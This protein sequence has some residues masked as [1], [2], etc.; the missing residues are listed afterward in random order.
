MIQNYHIFLNLLRPDTLIIVNNLKSKV[1]LIYAQK[2][3]NFVCII[4]NLDKYENV[5]NLLLI[6]KYYYI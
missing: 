5:N 6:C 1:K 3:T 4:C 2:T